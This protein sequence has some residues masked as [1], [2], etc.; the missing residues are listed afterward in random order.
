M[1]AEPSPG[2]YTMRTAQ[3]LS[4]DRYKKMECTDMVSIRDANGQ[5][6]IKVEDPTDEQVATLELFRASWEYRELLKEVIEYSKAMPIGLSLNL[7]E[8]IEKILE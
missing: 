4:D 5:R 1:K 6:I 2:P 3:P 8:R 7:V